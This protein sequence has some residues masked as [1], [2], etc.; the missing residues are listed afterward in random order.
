[1][2]IFHFMT[3]DAATMND[4]SVLKSQIAYFMQRL[5]RQ[6]L[7]TTSGGNISV[8]CDKTILITPSGSDKASLSADQIGEMDMEGHIVGK[9]F[10]PSIESRMH[11]AIYL[12]RP[13]VIAI[14]HA[15]PVAACTFAATDCS[16]NTAVGSEAYAILG[17]VVNAD[18]ARMGSDDLAGQVAAAALRSNAVIMR[19]HGALA[20]GH[21]LLEAFDRL[22]VLENAAQINLNLQR[23]PADRIAL[24]QEDELDGIDKY[25]RR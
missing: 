19:K 17:Q 1:M 16:I 4:K 20:L 12:C 13:D 6:K 5:Y 10:K 25:L 22:E 11:L 7:T 21:T 9:T 24:L 18:Y 3:G 2:G 15:H 14:V 23:F 8:R